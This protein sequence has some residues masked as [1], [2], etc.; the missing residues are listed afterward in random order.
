MRKKHD[1]DDDDESKKEIF[2]KSAFNIKMKFKI[3]FHFFIH[4]INR[5]ISER[6]IVIRIMTAQAI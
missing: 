5:N 4:I 2:E 1:D 3:L 6:I